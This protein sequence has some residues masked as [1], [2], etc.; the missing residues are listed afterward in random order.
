MKEEQNKN[1]NLI[2]SNG[3]KTFESQPNALNDEKVKNSIKQTSN[4]QL[5]IK[6]QDKE[7]QQKQPSSNKKKNKSKKKITNENESIVGEKDSLNIN[8][9]CKSYV[10][11]LSKKLF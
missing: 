4:E 9:L 6:P 5:S 2:K 3:F 7:K 11:R 1:S 10:I 8:N